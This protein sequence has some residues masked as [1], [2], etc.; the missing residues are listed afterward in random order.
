MLDEFDHAWAAG[1]RPSLESFLSNVASSKDQEFLIE[2][3]LIDLDYRMRAT[4]ARRESQ[5]V[6]SNEDQDAPSVSDYL[7]TYSSLVGDEE[8][9]ER[10]VV[11]EYASRLRHLIPTSVDAFAQQSP[12]LRLALRGRAAELNRNEPRFRLVYYNRRQRVADCSF[13]CSIELGRQHDSEPE[14]GLHEAKASTRFIIGSRNEKTV[15][16]R[17]LRV[18]AVLPNTLRL[19]NLSSYTRL[20]VN[21]TSSIGSGESCHQELPCLVNFLDRAVRFEELL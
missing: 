7:S 3:I 4:A 15:S 6:I 10:L 21:E 13:C 17:L 12:R 16:K 2:L 1:R 8:A 11:G 18:H 20:C 9:I 19:D 14:S 5:G